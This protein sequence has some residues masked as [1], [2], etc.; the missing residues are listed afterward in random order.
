VN[1]EAWRKLYPFQGAFFDR[2][3][4]I[5]MHWLDEGAGDPVVMVHGN[6]SWSFYYRALV[7]E[8]SR[9]H[10]CIVP[11]HVGCG[12]SDKPGD[13]SYTYTL[14]SRVDDLDALLEHAGVRERVTLV[15]HD[16]GGMIGHAWAVRHPERVARIVVLNTAAFHLP[17]SKRFPAL[18]RLARDFRAGAWLVERHNAFARG[19]TWLGVTRRKLAPE[20][21]EGLVAPYEPRDSRIATLRFV[22]DIPLA[23]GDRAYDLVTETEN[24]LA[25]LA[26]RPMLVCWGMKDF[27]FDRHFLAEWRRRFPKAEV[28][29]YPDAGHYVLEDAVEDVVPQVRDFIT[30]HPLAPV[31]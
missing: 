25:V 28:H 6:P 19:A 2:G 16:W 22:Q 12:L 18:L 11:D 10:R 27:V 13:E 4:G 26:D 31:G 20:V 17:P 8:L 5:R 29:E 24:K 7:R 30:R 15:V 9:D 21:S 14:K 1:Q 3:Q 23:P